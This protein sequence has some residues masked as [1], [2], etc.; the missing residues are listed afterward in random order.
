MSDQVIF[1]KEEVE[2]IRDCL[3]EGKSLAFSEGAN[4][5]EGK[6]DSGISLLDS[7][8]PMLKISL[9]T[10]HGLLNTTYGKG[11]DAL[12]QSAIRYMNLCGFDVKD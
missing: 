2:K 5:A 8:R 10:I 6:I 1:T 3:Y 4:I 9:E 11:L 7:P 12:E